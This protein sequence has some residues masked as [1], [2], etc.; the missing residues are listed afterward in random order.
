MD[1]FQLLIN[2]PFVEPRKL[3][4]KLLH[5]WNWSLD[6]IA[7]AEEEQ[8]MP[9]EG[10]P[11][12]GG[13]MSPEMMAMMQQQAGGEAPGGEVGLEPPALNGKQIPPEVLKGALSMLRK[14]G[15]SPHAAM[16]GK[17]A[18][19]EAGMPINLLASGAA[20]PTAKGISLPTSNPR[21]MN[22]GGK[23]NT[24]VAMKPGPSEDSKLANRALNIQK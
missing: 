8:Q 16:A 4:S 15:E 6:A 12:E 13:E 19:A 1:L 10:M 20:P 5:D 7:K 17:N 11:P 22:R 24:N 18:F 3:T 9:P 2:L 23:V 14:G 21:G